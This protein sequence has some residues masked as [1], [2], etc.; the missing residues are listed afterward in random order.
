MKRITGRLTEKNGKWY[1]VIN[2]YDVN[3]KRKEKWQ[4]LDLEAKRGSKTEA[5]YRLGEILSKYNCGDLYLQESLTHAEREKRRLADQTFDEYILEWLENHRVNISIMTYASYKN[6]TEARVVPYFREL[7]IPIKEVTGD[8]INAFYM[9]LRKDGLSGTTAQ[10]YHALLHLAFK[11]AVKRRIIPSN[12]CEQADRPKAT[13]YIGTYYN[14]E[15]IKKLIDCLGDDPLRIVV[16]LTAYYGLRRS[17][18]IGLKWDAIDLVDNKILVKHKVIENRIDGIKAEGYDVMKNDSSYRS[19]P[20]IPFIRDLLLEE[21]ERQAEMQRMLRS[22]YNREYQEYI[23]VDA[24]GDI[25][26]P[27]YVTDHFAVILRQNNL[28]KIRFHDLR[29][30]CAS[31]LLANK[32]PMKMIQDWLGHSDMGTT[33]NIYSHIDY[34]SKI[35]SATV[36]GNVLTS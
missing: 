33:A 3:G 12:P 27:R 24:I 30:S 1:A 11:Q 20:L 19:L 35:E 8:E 36:I 23:C 15:E 22:S 21:K 25:I 28:K 5:T 7:Q 29:H 14:S 31:L 10:R 2:L 32:I 9:A 17:E 26:T 4:S 34:S 18:V 16:I 6:M 13:R